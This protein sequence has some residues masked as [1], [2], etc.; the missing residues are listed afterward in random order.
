V[1]PYTA[2]ALGQLCIL[3]SVFAQY[4]LLRRVER[5]LDRIRFGGEGR[6]FHI[7]PAGRKADNKTTAVATLCTRKHKCLIANEPCNGF[8]RAS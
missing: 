8:P 1:N 3:V 2:L 5:R 4:M 7:P 6:V